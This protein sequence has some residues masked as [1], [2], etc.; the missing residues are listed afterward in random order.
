M[1]HL[2][3]N[4]VNGHFWQHRKEMGIYNILSKSVSKLNRS[5]GRSVRSHAAKQHLTKMVIS[6]LVFET[7]S[8]ENGTDR[9]DYR[10]RRRRRDGPSVGLDQRWKKGGEINSEERGTSP[11]FEQGEFCRDPNTE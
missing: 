9:A 6:K 10:R 4:M 7:R 5:G 8:K 2:D 11:S 3:T 1:F